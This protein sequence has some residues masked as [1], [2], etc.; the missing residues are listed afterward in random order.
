MMSSTTGLELAHSTLRDLRRWVLQTSV[1]SCPVHVRRKG[2]AVALTGRCSPAKMVG[3]APQQS[4][5]GL[6]GAFVDA[7]IQSH[8]FHTERCPCA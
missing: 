2:P 5:G 4:A 3:R 6:G 8:R 7:P 1:Q